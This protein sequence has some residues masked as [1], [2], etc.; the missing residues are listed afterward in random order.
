MKTL[1]KIWAIIG[2]T[3]RE[4]VAKK[5]FIVFF[6]L[7]TLTHLFFL[8]AIDVNLVNSAQ[9]MVQIFGQSV[10]KN[11][12][13]D[14]HKMII[15]IESFVAVF[16]AFVGG[17]FFS[18]FATAS[19]VPSM[20][21]KGNIEILLSKPLSRTQIFLGR[22]LGAQS[23]MVLNVLYLI[24]GTWLILSLKT[25]FWY[26]PFLYSIPMVVGAFAL[27][28]AFMA[29]VGLLTRSAGVSIMVAYAALLFSAIFTP[30]KEKFY[31]LLSQK[32]YL[33]F[34]SLYQI[35]PKTYDLGVIT[36][37]LVNNKSF[38]GWTALWTSG[39]AGLVMLVAS[40]FY[41]SKKDY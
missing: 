29:L 1:L 23:I 16:F 40:C 2:H 36:F 37:S 15:V 5:T 26:F 25:N 14:V 20:L 7:S 31:A 33:V 3:F 30:N 21:E 18:I 4:S 13:I 22:F 9:A 12:Q 19:L 34:D 39:I 28:Y 38:P 24:G 11:Q 27:M 6:I 17:I 32:L 8:F 41:F 35:L 10:G